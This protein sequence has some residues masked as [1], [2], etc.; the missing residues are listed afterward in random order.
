[1]AWGMSAICR[2][3]NALAEHKGVSL[4]RDLDYLPSFVKY[5]V[6]TKI[7]CQLIK[8]QIPRVDAAKISHA[9]K[10]KLQSTE[11]DN[12][13]IPELENDFEEAIQ[14]LNMFTNK[15]LKALEINRETI[16][17]ISRIRKKYQREI[18]NLESEPIF[19]FETI[20]LE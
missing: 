11:V 7:A 5:G 10:E 6:A 3:L 17:Q 4:T 20:D 8:L 13:E 12:N 15:E 18:T 19:E 14:S 1:M 2:Y 9:Y 16:K